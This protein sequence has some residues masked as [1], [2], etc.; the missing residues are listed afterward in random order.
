[1]FKKKIVSLAVK[2]GQKK[3]LF[4]LAKKIGFETNLFTIHFLGIL[5]LKF[6]YDNIILI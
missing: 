4:F 1:L 2:Y 6:G 3:N 5:R